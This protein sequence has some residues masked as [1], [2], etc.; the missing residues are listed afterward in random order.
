MNEQGRGIRLA[1]RVVVA[2]GE[3][4]VRATRSGG[5]GGQHVN[6]SST[7]IE[8]SWNVA[9]SPS[10]AEDV[11]ERLLDR[12][13]ARLHGEGILRVVASGSRSQRRNRQEALERMREL[14]QA[15]LKRRKRRRPTKP[16]RAA[17]QKRIDEK[18]R[19]SERKRRRRPPR[20]DE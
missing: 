9:A 20:P 11:R 5:P 19:R 2:P 12:L 15:A 13:S 18:K 8:L 17:V 1:P 6:T 10:I 3:L 16:S 4:E 14:V 7:R